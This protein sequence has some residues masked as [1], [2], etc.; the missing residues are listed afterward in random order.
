MVFDLENRESFT[1][2]IK[3]E[4]IMKE[5]GLD[6]NRSVIFVVGNKADVRSKVKYLS[7]ILYTILKLKENE[8]FKTNF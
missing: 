7:I 3:W 6:F 5:N 1:N 8:T 2:L 4:R